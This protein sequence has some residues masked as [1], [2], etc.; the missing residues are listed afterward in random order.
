MP[1]SVIENGEV[2]DIMHKRLGDNVTTVYL[3]DEYI[4][5][6]H[7]LWNGYSCFIKYP[8]PLGVVSGFKTRWQATAFLIQIRKVYKTE[9]KIT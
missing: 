9:Q 8:N 4:G 2:K 6:T 3:G 1:T 5:Q 7:K